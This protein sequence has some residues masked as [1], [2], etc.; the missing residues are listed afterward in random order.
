[1]RAF[2]GVWSIYYNEP[3]LIRKEKQI[4]F[5]KLCMW[6]FFQDVA[7]LCEMVTRS[8]ITQLDSFSVEFK[9]SHC[10]FRNI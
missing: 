3:P 6:V 9:G 2:T 7:K 5:V 4:L 10:Y 1:M 8:S